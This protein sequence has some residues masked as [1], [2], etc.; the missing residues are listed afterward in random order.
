[1]EQLG[2]YWK[3]FHEIWYLRFSR[4]S[5][6]KIQVSL[7]YDKNNGCFTLRP[8]HIYDNYVAELFVEWDM[9]QIKICWENQNTF[10]VH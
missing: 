7:Q 10:I 6:E 3:D 9:S 2:S 5:K 8:L 4:K 1:M